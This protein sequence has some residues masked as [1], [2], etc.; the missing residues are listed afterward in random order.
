MTLRRTLAVLVLGL[1][2]GA[3]VA[4]GRPPPPPPATQGEACELTGLIAQVRE[5]LDA[6]SPAYRRYLRRLLREAAATLPERQLH[7]AFARERDPAMVEELA[8]ALAARTDRLGEPGPLR[9]VAARAVEDADPRARAAAVRAL[10]NTSALEHAPEAYPRLVADPDPQVR[11]EAAQN[12]VVDNQEVF[13]GLHAPAAE[14]AVAAAIGAADPAVTAHVLGN[15][16]TQAIGAESARALE[17]LLAS[18]AVEVR[19]AAA[20]ALGGVP[21]QEGARARAALVE[22][23]HAERDPTVRKAI[24][25]SI[26]RLGFARAVPDLEALR[27]VDPTL[28]T[29]IDE[30]IRV[31]D[32]DLQEWSLLLREKRR[33]EQARS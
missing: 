27:R 5:G 21:A 7:D 13:A 30:W 20:T 8:A 11:R 14:A 24:L 3:P 16:S 23:F 25:E 33:L 18:P 31:L 26:V 15:V 10:R 17:G 1:A 2:A 22:L 6:A 9:A 32:L 12:L 28:S 29:D 4:I 19:V